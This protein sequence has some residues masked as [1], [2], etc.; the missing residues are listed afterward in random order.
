MEYHL[1]VWRPGYRA[2]RDGMI[3]HVNQDGYWAPLFAFDNLDDALVSQQQVEYEMG[4]PAK[5]RHVARRP[6]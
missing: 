5:L 6:S 2:Y 3:V 1:Y 4:E